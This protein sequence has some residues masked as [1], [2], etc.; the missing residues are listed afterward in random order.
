M[1]CYCFLGVNLDRKENS[2]KWYSIDLFFKTESLFY[3]EVSVI[4]I[5]NTSNTLVNI[6]STIIFYIKFIKI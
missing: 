6:T 1:C 5:A 4:I 3:I 2:I